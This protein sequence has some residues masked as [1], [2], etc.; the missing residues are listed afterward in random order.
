MSHLVT[1]VTDVLIALIAVRTWAL[2]HWVEE[3]VRTTMWAAERWGVHLLAF[4]DQLW[5]KA[6]FSR[7]LRSEA[8]AS[9]VVDHQLAVVGGFEEWH[10]S[11]LVGS[12]KR[13]SCNR[14]C[15]CLVKE[16]E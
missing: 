5:R 7:L 3:Y 10:F 4:T 11:S 1:D 12:P 15:L 8:R 14:Q 6:A 9:A 16:K 13:R 2:A